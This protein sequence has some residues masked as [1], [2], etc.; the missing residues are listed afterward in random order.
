MTDSPPYAANLTI[1]EG[2]NRDEVTV[3]AT[4][5]LDV[6]HATE[7]MHGDVIFALARCAA[8]A[9][10]TADKS[11]REWVGHIFSMAMRICL[12]TVFAME[13]EAMGEGEEGPELEEAIAVALAE[14]QKATK[15]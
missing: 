5:L 15:Q 14:A 11:K 1:A 13:K 9:V 7:R 10:L 6:I 4:Q 8:G 12:A 2:L 3:L